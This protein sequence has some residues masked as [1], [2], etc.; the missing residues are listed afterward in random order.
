MCTGG[1]PSKPHCWHMNATMS[2]VRG[3]AC[4][5][6]CPGLWVARQLAPL[7]NTPMWLLKLFPLVSEGTRSPNLLNQNSIQK[8]IKNRL[9]LGNVCYYLVQNILSSS[10]KSKNVKIKIYRTIILPVVLYSCETWSLTLREEQRFR[11]IFGHKRDK[12]TGEWRRLHNEGLH[13]LYSWPIIIHVIKST[14]LI[15]IGHVACI[16]GR[17]GAY[18][19]LVWKL[20]GSLGRSRY[21]RRI[22]VLRE[23]EWWGKD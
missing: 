18:R 1:L 19:V 17:R 13:A 2:S 23:V 3:G 12:V 8:E 7:P 11:R 4:P 16:G 10:L 15:W 22:M 21:G 5:R 6:T 20:E 14:R 9:K